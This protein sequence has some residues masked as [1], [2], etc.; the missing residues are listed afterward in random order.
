MLEGIDD[1]VNN[2]PLSKEQSVP[3]ALPIT[4]LVSKMDGFD[5]EFVYLAYTSLSR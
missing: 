5:V 1:G 2:A 4:S 3:S